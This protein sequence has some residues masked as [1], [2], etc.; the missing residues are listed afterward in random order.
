MTYVD[1]TIPTDPTE[2][3]PVNIVLIVGK[4]QNADFIEKMTMGVYS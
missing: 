3:N 4:D 2:N 1:T